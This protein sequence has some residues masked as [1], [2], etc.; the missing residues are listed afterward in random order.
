MAKRLVREQDALLLLE[1][2]LGWTDGEI[3]ADLRAYPDTTPDD[4]SGTRDLILQW[5]RAENGGTS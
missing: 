5:I 1:R 3:E 4:A 2:L